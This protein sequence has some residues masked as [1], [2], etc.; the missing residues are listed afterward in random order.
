M[1]EEGM[2][3]GRH[4]WIGFWL[5]LVLFLYV[6]IIPPWSL[7]K[8]LMIV[9]LTIALFVSTTLLPPSPGYQV[10]KKKWYEETG[11]TFMINAL[12]YNKKRGREELIDF[13]RRL[14]E[15]VRKMDMG[16]RR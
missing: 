3:R 16:V 9:I 5:L 15:R 1:I 12:E 11:T 4:Y 13:D 7:I 14:A 2:K 8:I 6:T 10:S